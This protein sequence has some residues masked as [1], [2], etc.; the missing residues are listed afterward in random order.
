[1]AYHVIVAQGIS[2]GPG[3]GPSVDGLQTSKPSQDPL[4]QATT[5]THGM[6]VTLHTSGEVLC[7]KHLLQITQSLLT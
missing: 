7:N 1:M 5:A 2:S 3:Q 6:H 4:K